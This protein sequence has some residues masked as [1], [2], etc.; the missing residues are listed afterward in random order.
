MIKGLGRRYMPSARG[1]CVNCT[2]EVRCAGRRG[3]PEDARTH[4]GGGAY[5]HLGRLGP[6]HL[7][8]RAPQPIAAKMVMMNPDASVV[9]A[10]LVIT[11]V[12]P[13]DR[14]AITRIS[15]IN[16]RLKVSG[17]G[18]AVLRW[19]VKGLFLSQLLLKGTAP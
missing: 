16:S 14:A 18:D 10:A 2:I 17:W 12:A 5:E 11:S 15:E 13:S 19:R 1:W 4:L 7:P 8:R 6:T 3:Q 9:V